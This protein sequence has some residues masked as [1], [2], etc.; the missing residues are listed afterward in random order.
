MPE[1]RDWSVPAPLRA[2][3][4]WPPIALVLAVLDPSAAAGTI[5]LTGGGLALLGLVGAA[6]GGAV[7]RRLDTG[8]G[9]NAEPAARTLA[10][11]TIT[12]S[13]AEQRAA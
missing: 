10:M 7:S 1:A 6:L 5:A 3:L 2:L 4:W 13:G 12:R 9:T 11:E 8:D